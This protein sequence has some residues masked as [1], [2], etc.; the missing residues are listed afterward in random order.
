MMLDCTRKI[1][2]THLYAMDQI[3]INGRTMSPN[4]KKKI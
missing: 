2:T 4:K 3:W 1:I